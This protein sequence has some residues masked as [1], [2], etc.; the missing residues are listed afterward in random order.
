[1]NGFFSAN[2]RMRCRGVGPQGAWTKTADGL[3]HG[4]FRAQCAVGATKTAE[5]ARA[6]KSQPTTEIPKQAMRK[7]RLCKLCAT[8]DDG[9]GDRQLRRWQGAATSSGV[10]RVK[11]RRRQPSGAGT[12]HQS[13]Q[14]FSSISSIRKHC[15][16]RSRVEVGMSSFAVAMAEGQVDFSRCAPG[17]LEPQHQGAAHQA[18]R[19][20]A[21]GASQKD[22]SN[23]RAEGIEKQL[24]FKRPQN[25]RKNLLTISETRT[26]ENSQ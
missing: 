5:R 8:V 19:T 11:S 22:Q 18:P 1:M 16:G 6:G 21:N 25:N 2:A 20:R 26:R 15:R 14:S 13:H 10:H 9:Q 3:R 24:T 23:R 17:E 4:H 7:P 12:W